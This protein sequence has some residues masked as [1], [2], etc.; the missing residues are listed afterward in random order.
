MVNKDFQKQKQ[1]A[2]KTQWKKTQSLPMRYSR[3]S[4]ENKL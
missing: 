3:S 4:A 1:Y 2:Q